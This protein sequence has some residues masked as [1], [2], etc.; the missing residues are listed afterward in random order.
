MLDQQYLLQVLSKVVENGENRTF[1]DVTEIINYM[2][3]QLK[4]IIDHVG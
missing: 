1:D 3:S 4:P 2:V